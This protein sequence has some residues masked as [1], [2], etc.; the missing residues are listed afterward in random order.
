MDKKDIY[1]HLAN[2]YLDASANKKGKKKAYARFIKNPFLISIILL[3][4]FSSAVLI[5]S[6][7]RNRSL[8]N[9]E[10]ALVLLHD[11]VKINFHFD[12][13]KKETFTLNLNRLNLSNFRA[14]EF[15]VKKAG[16]QN[17]IALRVGF[18]NRFKEKS[19]VYFKEIPHKWHTYRINLSDFKNINDWSEVLTLSFATEEW[20]VK[21]KKGL[22]YIDNIRLLK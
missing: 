22:V 4:S 2:I 16:Y 20:N 10:V 9:S 13:A 6:F 5:L 11:A 8:A 21:E 7:Q 18:A 3:F 14:L 1:E 19:E 17:N 12:P 15:S